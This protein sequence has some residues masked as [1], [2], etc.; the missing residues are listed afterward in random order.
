MRVFP[1][2]ETACP[3]SCAE[4]GAVEAHEVVV[5]D[6]VAESVQEARRHHLGAGREPVVPA[7]VEAQ[8]IEIILGVGDEQS[9][10]HAERLDDQDLP[11]RGG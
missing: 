3:F 11:R 5:D 2:L 1:A 7:R 10:V 4:L 6:E 8:E 9:R